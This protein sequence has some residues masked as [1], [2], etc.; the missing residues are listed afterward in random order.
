M[1]RIII[2]FFLSLS[3]FFL[4]AQEWT[5]NL[6]QK[7]TED[8]S[9]RDYQKAFNE[10]WAPYDVDNKAKYIDSDGVE[11]K[12]S[13][14]KQFKRWEWNWEPQVDA[15]T[16]AFPNTTALEEYKKWK[17]NYPEAKSKSADW[18][19]LGPTT[20]NS[21]YSGIGRIN[22][23]N[24]HPVDVNTYWVG[25]PA[26]GLWVTEN[27]GLSWTNL[28]DDN[29]VLG[30]S[31]IVIP[32]DYETSGIIYIGTGDKDGWDNRSLGVLKSEDYGQT[33]NPTD[34]SFTFAQ[35]RMVSRLLID[36][37]DNQ[38]LIAG[39]NAG[40]FKTT[41]GGV[42]WSEQLTSNSFIDMEY[43]P[44][45][46]DVLYGSTTGGLVFKSDDGGTGW[47]QVLSLSAGRIELAVTPDNPQVLYV[48]VSAN[49]NGL[50]G[51]YKSTDSGDSFSQVFDGTI[52]GNN[53]MGWYEGNSTGGQG[54]YDLSMA[55]SPNNEDVLLIGGVNTWRSQDG[56]SNWDM[57]NH[58]Y[59][60]FGAQ[61]VHADKHM[62]K[63]RA[64]GDLFECN[65]GGI[66]YSNSDGDID[67][68]ID[69]S[70]GMMISQMYKLGTSKTVADETITGL[71][72]NGT[73]LLSGSYWADVK[74][75]D[76]MECLIDY[77]DVNVQYG[78]YVR[79]QI[80]RTTNHW[81]SE[82]DISPSGAGDG[83]WVT[84]YIIDPIENETLY[85][86]YSGIWKTTNR[87]NSWV[88]LTGVSSGNKI[89]SMAISHSNTQVI[90]VADE[91]NIWK[92]TDGG[93]SWNP[94][95]S[96]LPYNTITY[97]AV[98]NNNSDKLWVTLGDYD[99][100]AVYESSDGGSSWVNISA[101]LPQIPAY[102]IV[103]NK[104]ESASENLY[105]GTELGVYFKNGNADWVEFNTGLP[106]VKIGELEMYY[107]ENNPV[108][109]KLRAATY[110][111]GLWETTPELSGA[112]AP[113]V[114]TGGSANVTMSSVDL[115]GSIVNDF[116]TG[117]D[118]SGII[119][120]TEPN[121]LPGGTGVVS[122]Q[123]DPPVVTG[124]Y[125]LSFNGLNHSTTYYYRAYA[126]N[127][128]GTGL[129]GSNSFTTVCSVVSDLPYSEGFEGGGDFPNC[130]SQEFV[131]GDNIQWQK[132]EGCGSNAPNEA[133][134]GNFNMFFDESDT[135]EDKTKLVSPVYN[136]TGLT[137][138]KLSFWMA[139]PSFFQFQDELRV[140]YKNSDD[141]EWVELVNYNTD[142]PEW[143]EQ[144]ISLPETSEYYQIAFEANGLYGNGI[145]ID[146]VGIIESTGILGE[147]NT[148]FRVYPNPSEGML[149]IENNLNE[150]ITVNINDITGRQL[151]K[152]NLA[153]G[154]RKI[155]LSSF[156]SG[157][158]FIKA[159]TQ[160]G[161]YSKRIV[162][163]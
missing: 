161:T 18:T 6:P 81:G 145:C 28:T 37:N 38:T 159:E 152:I 34:L 86:G 78:T 99:E 115:T 30:V 123:T 87:G 71:Q 54:W 162:I 22:A 58:W 79:G 140:Y 55:V 5:N 92:T 25:A 39:T 80:S 42:N 160:S 101:G 76:G 103:Y 67:S 97:I 73:K 104:M 133:H 51:I 148:K 31:D 121:P 26:G 147:E 134:S 127:A 77:T 20:S 143:T 98:K 70:N 27:N 48:D 88:Q 96:G 113:A 117:V 56:G 126:V 19:P 107:D 118:E 157:I 156:G 128:N 69:K 83:A 62:L 163:Q 129:G 130:W 53:L 47:T 11:R 154:T 125:S 59:G 132:G 93:D 111:R 108:N 136:F 120:G 85:A 1:K 84:P 155:D 9:L 61:A 33:W 75:G 146:D 10:Y 149:Y 139:A 141:A 41:D 2:I 105:V 36:P 100:H 13:G 116:G 29:S 14:W 49:N 151:R 3:V 57:V 109:M 138:A 68:W 15:K 74:G 60:G 114:A 7:A 131:S 144:I 82:T 50:Y 110:G 135:G 119:L 112:Y 153:V 66:Y 21:G 17:K 45:N 52:S 32:S 35:N 102:S 90:Y 4:N 94:I 24:F 23:V 158:Y 106:N 46:F 124:E 137:G 64:D 89:R 43:K 65:D 142:I 122:L 16:G 72:D 40:V 63:Y 150:E 44:G 8:Y 91:N 12:A 95:S